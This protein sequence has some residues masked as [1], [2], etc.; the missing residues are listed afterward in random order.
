MYQGMRPHLS[1]PRFVEAA[2]WRI[3]L[4]P[5]ILSLSLTLVLSPNTACADCL[6]Y[7]VYFER[8]ADFAIG[9]SPEKV[10]LRPPYAFMAGGEAGFLVVDISD[11][12]A[13][14]LVA[15]WDPNSNIA[16]LALSGDYAYL[17]DRNSHFHVVDIHDPEAPTLLGTVE[18]PGTG[19][20]VASAGSYA[21]VVTID[22][23]LTMVSAVNP[24]HPA[25]V[26]FFDT[27]GRALDVAVEG[28]FAYVADDFPYGLQVV[29]ISD[30]ASPQGIAQF[31][32]YDPAKTISIADG[33]AYIGEEMPPPDVFASLEIVD[34]TNPHAPVG[35]GH[36][37]TPQRVQDV[38]VA[39]GR[40]YLAEY[41]IYFS[42]RYPSC[43]V[44]DVSDPSNPTILADGPLGWASG[45]GLEEGR[46]WLADYG[47]QQLSDFDVQDAYP[48]IAAAETPGEA[49]DVALRGGWAYVADRSG[50]LVTFDVTGPG[51]PVVVSATPTPGPAR[52]VATAADL[53]CVACETAGIAVYGMADPSAPVLL[54]QA[55]TPGSARRVVIRGDDLF[56]ADLTGG[57]AVVSL[58]DPAHPSV[59]GSLALP[60]ARDLVVEGPYAYLACGA[61][62][63]RI[64]DVSNP[65]NP[66]LM[67]S[68]S[69]G[70][71]S[72]GIA[73]SGN[74]VLVVQA[75]GV[76]HVIDVTSPSR[77]SLLGSE[78]P[79]EETGSSIAAYG[80]LVFV[81]GSVSGQGR[82][83][84]VDV[85]QPGAPMR[86]GA[87][88]A[89][90]NV[91]SLRFA[92]DRLYQAVSSRGLEVAQGHCPAAGVPEANLPHFGWANLEALPNPS[93]G[94]VRI[95]LNLAEP[96]S[97]HAVIM[98]VAGRVVRRLEVAETPAG[99]VALLWDGRD[100]RGRAL[101]GG[102]YWARVQSNQGVSGLRLI[103]VR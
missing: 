36:L 74:L 3:L 31:W 82:V 83:R 81:G 65:T 92:G 33:L 56:A 66:S 11:P 43:Q 93:A 27:P 90:Q 14:H 40:A 78:W 21:A 57:L 34:L 86:R 59:V 96:S 58:T 16:D 32:T 22:H 6:D 53:L 80:D 87:F 54:G 79:A 44:A 76:L 68:L 28:N 91:L 71:T 88:R 19:M 12:A 49:N 45:I 48:Q 51:D 1:R 35:L 73:K 18:V 10:V 20:A 23:G 67:G 26:G 84:V 24:A 98:D 72:V 102:S 30:P 85:S 101:P 63:L 7:H 70:G 95:L 97:V 64:A 100:D 13:P 50:G 75:D 2:S 41:S 62:G 60:D 99:R 29:D 4:V 77:P 37:A 69:L 39:E 9:N 38:A 25:V 103:L 42:S 61:S 5:V 94:P 55:A 46:I 17:V 52:G 47:H 8:L 15:A 89:E